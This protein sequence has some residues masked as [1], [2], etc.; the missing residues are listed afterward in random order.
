MIL[1]QTDKTVKCGLKL[2]QKNAHKIVRKENIND[3]TINEDALQRYLAGKKEK[4]D[5][6]KNFKNFCLRIKK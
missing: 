2:L 1:N 3:G 5:L 6:W 4:D